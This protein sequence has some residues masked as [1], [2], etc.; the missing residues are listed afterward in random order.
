MRAPQ[1]PD[2][3][4]CGDAQG[5]LLVEPVVLCRKSYPRIDTIGSPGTCVYDGVVGQRNR[6]KH[7]RLD[8]ALPALGKKDPRRLRFN[9]HPGLRKQVLESSWWKDTIRVADSTGYVPDVEPKDSVDQDTNRRHRVKILP[10]I[11]LFGL[12]VTDYD[13]LSARPR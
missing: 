12:P 9:E 7:R 1:C 6:I 5:T 3:G 11:K 4:A 13:P 2:T 10:I 8:A